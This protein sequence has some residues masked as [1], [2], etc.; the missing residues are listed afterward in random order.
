MVKALKFAHQRE[1]AKPIARIMT[2]LL[3]QYVEDFDSYVLVP[4]PTA[5]SRVRQRSFDHTILLAQSI[6]NM[7]KLPTRNFL[8]RLGQSRQVGAKREDRVR[9]AAGVYYARSRNIKGRKILLIDD[10]VTTGATLQAATK[11]LR[12]AGAS[13]VDALVFAKRV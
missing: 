10:V 1:M 6:S 11:V 12:A 3:N 8:K 13:K 5:T 4:I 9:Q 2:D 7:T